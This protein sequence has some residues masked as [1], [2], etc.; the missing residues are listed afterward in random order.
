[1]SGGVNGGAYPRDAGTETDMVVRRRPGDETVAHRPRSAGPHGQG[2]WWAVSARRP[3]PGR[4]AARRKQR[5]PRPFCPACSARATGSRMRALTLFTS[6]GAPAT[7][8]HAFAVPAPARV[9]AIANSGSTSIRAWPA[10]R[11]TRPARRSPSQG[12]TGCAREHATKPGRRR[13]AGRG[14]SV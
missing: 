14:N 2:S 8:G 1:M 9:P 13:P 4:R 11:G 7:V 6:T 5:W 10:G 12:G 3:P